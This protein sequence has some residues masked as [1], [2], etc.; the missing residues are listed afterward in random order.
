MLGHYTIL[1]LD[2]AEHSI[3]DAARAA[4]LVFINGL[5][6]THG[7]RAN[8]SHPLALLR[9]GRERPRYRRAADERD[10]LASPT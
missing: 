6:P 7:E 8:A 4:H 5:V 2:A 9:A 1:R 3:L 10:E